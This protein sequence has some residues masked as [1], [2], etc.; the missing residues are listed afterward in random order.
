MNA[1]TRR[2]LTSELVTLTAV[3]SIADHPK[4]CGTRH[5]PDRA[6]GGAGV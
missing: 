2:N 3:R 5:A 6:T 4:P 1:G